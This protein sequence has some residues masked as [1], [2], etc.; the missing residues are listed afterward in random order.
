M[1]SRSKGMILESDAKLLSGLQLIKINLFGPP[2]VIVCSRVRQFEDKKA[3][4]S[5]NSNVFT[6]L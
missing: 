3:V 1:V 5:P 4:F 2:Y 6:G